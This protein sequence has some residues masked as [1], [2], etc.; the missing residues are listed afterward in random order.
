MASVNSYGY[1]RQEDI[2]HAWLDKDYY[3]VEDWHKR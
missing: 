1:L 2:V 3:S